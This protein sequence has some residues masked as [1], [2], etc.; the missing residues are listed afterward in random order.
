MTEQI[1][2]GPYK[3]YKAAIHWSAEDKVF[4]GH[5][6]IEQDYLPIMGYTKKK[7]EADFRS[8]I[9]EYLAFCKRVG[10]ISEKP[11]P[12]IQQDML[13]IGRAETGFNEI[14]VKKQLQQDQKYQE[15]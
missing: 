1:V 13:F 9:T 15:E 3:G 12:L 4:L 10:K 8:T 6:N 11:I 2:L 5:I 7:A 14:K